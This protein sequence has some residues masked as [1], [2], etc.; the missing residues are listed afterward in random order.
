M[1]KIL[2]PLPVM[3][4][5]IMLFS[6]HALA[7]ETRKFSFVGGA[8][9]I[10]Y[11]D[12]LKE[13]LPEADT[14]TAPKINS[15]HVLADLGINIRP[16]KSTEIQGMIRIRNDYGGFW[17]SGVSFDVR[18]LY[19]KGVIGG[20]FRYQLGDIN[21]KMTKYTL[22]NSNQEIVS[23]MPVVFQQ[24]TDN[25]VNYDNFYSQ[26]NSWRQQGGA[27]EFGL[28]FNK[29]VQELQFHGVTTRMKASNNNTLNDR[30]FSGLNLYL[31]QSGYFEAG[32]N[33]AN[34]YDIP[35]TSNNT[36]IFHNPVITGTLKFIYNRE[37]WKSDIVAEF[38]N[39][40]TSYDEDTLA[41]ELK[42]QFFDVTAS[43]KNVQSGFSVS[44][45][46]QRIGPDF[47]S[48]G[49]QTKRINYTA[50]PAAYQRITNDQ[51]LRPITMMDLMRESDLYYTQLNSNLTE[52]NPGYDNI[53]PYG[54]ATPNR[55]GWSIGASWQKETI[56]VSAAVAWTSLEE[57][58]GQ[59]T[60][61]PHHY[62]RLDLSAESDI[63]RFLKNYS[64]LIHASF[65]YRMDATKRDA[66]EL[67]KPVDLKTNVA[68]FG[69]EIETFK[70][71]DVMLGFQ[72]LS[73]NGFDFM[74]IRNN[75]S[76]VI[77]FA[78]YEADGKET[79]TALG[80]RYRFTEKIF[81][82]GQMSNLKVEDS[83]GEIPTYRI[84]QFMLLFQMSF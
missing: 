28:V 57:V 27:A 72:S 50:Y 63:N 45:G 56:P 21:Y 75:Y 19:I 14:V 48:P 36:T 5:C 23:N 16:N 33:Y 77:N 25:L 12:D 24:Q 31:V 10:F 64:R 81:L 40:K 69:L 52:M 46:L 8:R 15:G 41:P 22:W 49:S 53:T 67:I 9:G 78:E 51:I 66:E 29:Y 80:L 35:G 58:R 1:E 37:E 42:D 17:G 26:D 34:V 79:M 55:Q 44:A 73:Y 84:Q 68:S 11:G 3:L 83:T 62:S 4:V 18:Q 30:L 47:R 76:E 39:S 59:G 74:A 65:S 60:L 13:D 7:Q 71:L 2:K 20:I 54:A 38:G 32:F 61:E 82:T 43:V 70:S 6:M